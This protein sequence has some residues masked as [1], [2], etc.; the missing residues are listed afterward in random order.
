MSWLLPVLAVALGAA[1]YALW[2]RREGL[3]ALESYRRGQLAELSA[4][5]GNLQEA[6]LIVDADN[7]VLLANQALR[8]IFGDS[9]KIVGQRL[10]WLRHGGALLEYLEAVRGR[11]P[12]PRR[13]IEFR[14]QQAACI[15]ESPVGASSPHADARSSVWVEVAGTLMPPLDGAA[16]AGGAGGQGAWVLVILHD[17]SHQRK[18]EA[19]RKDFVANVS[20]E[21]RTPLSV[22]MGYVETLV[23][24]HETI[25][26]ETRERFL[27]TIQRHTQR[28]NS[29][30]D[31]LLSLSRLESDAPGLVCEPVDLGRLLREVVEDYRGRPVSVGHALRLAIDP[32]LCAAG[33]GAPIVRGDA[34][35]LTQVL[36][37][38][39]DNALKYTPASSQIVVSA[40]LRQTG[41]RAAAANLPGEGLRAQGGS[42]ADE[43]R[44]IPAQELAVSPAPEQPAKGQ[45]SPRAATAAEVEICVRDNGAGIPAED[46][47]HIFE[48]FYRVDKGRSR[49]Q[50]GTG[51]GLSIVKHIVQLHGGRVWAESR[52]GAH[53]AGKRAPSA[54]AAPCAAG[55]ATGKGEPQAGSDAAGQG[56]AFYFTLPCEDASPPRSTP[57]RY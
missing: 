24:G 39:I 37:N 4:T 30:L 50:G 40:R 43:T 54:E 22:I 9:E 42:P 45:G 41:G 1:F 29:L 12:T 32:A 16:G 55:A 51:L 34:L 49:A 36:E 10:E 57:P 14:P 5:L 8:A 19:V 56:T 15:G 52:S 25:P 11:Q 3:L 35:K 53:P 33:A 27:R 21:L 31:D 7:R 46:L 17:I 18:L 47:P 38:L 26:P 44:E 13:A 6:V 2:A 48:R 20:H 23:D 28:L